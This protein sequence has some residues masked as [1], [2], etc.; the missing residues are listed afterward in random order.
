M[1]FCSYMVNSQE[2]D[3]LTNDKVIKLHQAGFSNEVLKSKIQT[4]LSKFDVTMNGLMT[5]KKA[6]ISDDVINM[7]I[8]KPNQS[9]NSITTNTNSVNS[10][11]K[12]IP[13]LS[14]GI[15]YKTPK[16]EY[17]EIEPSVLTSS[18]TNKA[19]QFF[20][21]GLINSKQKASLSG[22]KSS[23]EIN[24]SRP[25]IVFVF[26]VSMKNNLNNDNN[27]FFSNARSPKEFILVK[28]E[29]TKKSR[30]ITVSKGNVISSNAG[31]D[32]NSV[33][34]FTTKIIAYTMSAIILISCRTQKEAQDITQS[35]DFILLDSK[36]EN[37]ISGYNNG[38]RSTEYYFNTESYFR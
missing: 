13:N 19:A 34:Q 36:Y 35:S 32:D 30:E 15:Y 37:N 20:V 33:M 3:V 17:L 23:F 7:M 27:Q 11:D 2:T 22:S 29:A 26:D 18:N 16:N 10:I 12:E 14:S 4:S 38:V 21:S 31:I 24:N 25:T 1:I 8:A 5:L 28:L 6:G 9:N